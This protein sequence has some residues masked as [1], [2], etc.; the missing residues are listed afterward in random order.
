MKRLTVLY[1]A[2]CGFCVRCRRWLLAQP[3]LLDLDFVAARSPEAAR[4]FAELDGEA[5]TDELVVV[6]DEGGV[7]RGARAWIMCLYALAEYREWS[8]RLARPS[9]LP[10]ARRAFEAISRNRRRLT[11]LLRLGSDEE[12]ASTLGGAVETACPRT[13]RG[14]TPSCS[15]SGPRAA[16]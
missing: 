16:R 12:V 8:L 10:F 4:R 2:S 7:Y 6:S 5:E 9:L 1:D 3:Q 11:R 13:A 15:A 14:L